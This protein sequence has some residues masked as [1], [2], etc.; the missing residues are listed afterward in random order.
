M[1][2]RRNVL[3]SLSLPLFASSLANAKD[4]PD[5]NRGEEEIEEAKFSK[6]F[7]RLKGDEGFRQAVFEGDA[8]RVIQFFNKATQTDYLVVIVFRGQGKSNIRFN[9]DCNKNAKG[10][11]TFTVT[12]S[13]R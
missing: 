4:L 6:A 5:W 12:L 2:N 13:R 10:Q 1:I 9:I 7:Q 11:W 8:E 3:L